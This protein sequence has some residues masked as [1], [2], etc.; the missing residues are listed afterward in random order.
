MK[1]KVMIYAALFMAF[2]FSLT[3]QNMVP[4][5]SFE[6]IIKCVSSDQQYTGYVKDWIG[7]DGGGGIAYCTSQC[8]GF[9]VGMPNNELGFQYAHSGKS[10]SEIWTFANLSQTDTIFPY[11]Y[12][13]G[14]NARDY[15]EAQLTGTLKAGMIYYVNF[16][17]S[18]ADSSIYACGDI[19]AYFSDSLISMN[20]TYAK[21]YLTPQIAN[22]FVKSPLTDTMNWIR[23]SGSFIA[24]GGEQY[25]VIGNFKNDSLSSIKY[26][27][28]RS[29]NG[30][31]A[32]Y[33]IDDVIV[34]PDSNYADSL[35]SVGVENINKPKE[36]VSVYPNPSNGVF[37]FRMQG[38]NQK[39][40]MDIYNILGEQVYNKSINSESTQIDLSNQPKGLYLYR[41][42]SE[43][44]ELTGTGKLVIQ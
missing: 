38:A 12:K 34:S 8:S 32:Y 41:I 11:G 39:A 9:G 4:N 17:V 10:Y 15:I 7:Q 43:K 37:T 29:V 19:G 31:A 6:N 26:L 28:T 27:G 33:Y 20:G 21:T 18:L 1:S 5:Y 13:G 40:Q 3:A 22:N 35:F 30:T 36:V 44:G 42:T 25:I 24:N 14:F 23:I 2:S 16:F